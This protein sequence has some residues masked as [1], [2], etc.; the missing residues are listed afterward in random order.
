M[1]DAFTAGVAPGG[2]TF[3]SD[4]RI[5]ICYLVKSVP[6]S[7]TKANI[8]EVLQEKQLANYFELADSVGLLEQRGHIIKDE[9]GLFYLSETGLEIAMSLDTNL[10]PVV[11]DKALE[12]AFAMLKHARTV[13]ENPVEINKTENGYDVVCHISGGSFD[14]MKISIF[15]PDKM[16][17]KMIKQNFQ[18]DPQYLYSLMLSAM[19]GDKAYIKSLI[20]EEEKPKLIYEE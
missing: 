16:Q 2:L 6:H 7:L 20:E 4:I 12:S 9:D 10:P 13:R 18:N 3:K 1:S 19:V 5:L 14:L 17:A 15:A 8:I 11:R